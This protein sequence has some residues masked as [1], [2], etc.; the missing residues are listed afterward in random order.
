[1]D[2]SR[3]D[4]KRQMRRRKGT[5]ILAALAIG[6][7]CVPVSAGAE[8]L[9]DEPYPAKLS[10][11]ETFEVCKSGQI[12]CPAISPICDN[13]KVAVPVDTP[14][15]LG[16]KG[17]APGTTLCSA[18]S[19]AGPRRVFASSFADPATVAVPAQRAAHVVM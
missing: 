4:R 11:G 9:G 8:M 1:M 7:F 5:A 13:L 12:V 6:T 18:A 10:T 2:E 15:G 3:D 17:V 14:D 16:F 19:A